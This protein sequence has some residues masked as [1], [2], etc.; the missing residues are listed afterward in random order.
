MN[1]TSYSDIN[2]PQ[3]HV[4]IGFVIVFSLF[5]TVGILHHLEDSPEY[6]N[7]ISLFEY[8]IIGHIVSLFCRIIIEFLSLNRV[9][10]SVVLGKLLV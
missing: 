6:I 4:I 1:R 8:M 3:E 10:L 5:L 2:I 7:T 9:A